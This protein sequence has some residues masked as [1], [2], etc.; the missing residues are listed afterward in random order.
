MGWRFVKKIGWVAGKIRADAKHLGL[1]EVA[2]VVGSLD[3]FTAGFLL[4][5]LLLGNFAIAQ[6]LLN[7]LQ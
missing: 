6:S 2:G 7:L 4:L 1:R 5:E 3:D